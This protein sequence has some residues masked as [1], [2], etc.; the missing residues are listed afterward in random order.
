ME[1]KLKKH[2]QFRMVW[3]RLKKNKLS[4]VGLFIVC[5]LAFCAIF[6]DFIAPYSYDQM[7]LLHTFQMP[8]REHLLGTDNFGYDIFEPFD[9]WLQSFFDRRLH[10]S[11]NRPF[12]WRNVRGGFSFL[13]RKD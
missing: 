2:S 1:A 11:G 4:M 3:H 12:V 10:I 5:L 8:C 9:L 13:W 6:A 7:D